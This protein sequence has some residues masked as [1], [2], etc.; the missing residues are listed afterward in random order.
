MLCGYRLYIGGQLVNVG[1]GR[2]EA[3][4]WG[5]NGT[6]M[7]KPYQ[8][9]DVTSHVLAAL[10]ENNNGVLIAIQG[11][12]STGAKGT[13]GPACAGP[14]AGI[15]PKISAGVLMQLA[16]ELQDG[17][18]S[19]VVTDRTWDAFDADTYMHPSPGKNWY[20]HVLENTDARDEPTGWRSDLHFKTSGSGWAKAVE[21][22]PVRGGVL[23]LHPKMSRPIQSFAVP[24]P[25]NIVK[26]D[27]SVLGR[28]GCYTI[29]FT[30]EFQVIIVDFK[31]MQ[32]SWSVLW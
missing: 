11:L 22:L 26:L 10:G 31:R 4:V 14:C 28:P 16:L 25:S 5:G 8:T 21:I 15:G 7:E 19:T 17:K 27:P 6:Y 29:D 20:K 30:R 18:T 23:G 32:H 2:G 1:P 12:G 3:V 24:A 9:L 13:S